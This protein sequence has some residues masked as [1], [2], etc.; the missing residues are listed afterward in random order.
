MSVSAGD[1]ERVYDPS[2][3]ESEPW[4]INDHTFVRDRNGTWHLIGITHAEPIGAARREAP[5]PRH[6]ARVA[7]AVDQ[8]AVRALCRSR[9]AARRTC[10]RRT[11]IVHDDRYWMFVL[12]RRRWTRPRTASNSRRRTT[13]VTWTRH[14]ANPLVVDGFEARDPMVLAGRRPLG[15]VL[16]G[17]H[18]AERRAVTSWRP[19]SPTT[20]CTGR[21]RHVVYTDERV[22][23][24]GGPTE[25][26]FVVER[27]GRYY[28]FIG[29]DW[30]HGR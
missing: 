14:A 15:H 4:Y 20:S 28:L 10:G 7:R 1:F 13:A 12:R 25:S 22:G 21:G 23:T 5:R 9:R 27:D 24:F 3:G 29:P 17:D 11:S 18:D 16:H 2:V 26:P 6:R 19:S 8:A 30:G